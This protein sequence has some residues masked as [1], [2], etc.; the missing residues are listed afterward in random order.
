MKRRDFF[1]CGAVGIMGVTLGDSS[2]AETEKIT[3]W[4]ELTAFYPKPKGGHMPM[5]ELGK[6]GI[7]VS[8]L[9]FGS[10]IRAEMRKYDY[11]REYMMHEAHDLGV[12]VFDVYDQEEG[13]ST[14]GSYQYEPLARQIKPFKNEALVSISFRPYEGRTDEQ[15]LERDLKIFDRDAIDLV[16]ILRQPE[17]PIWG[18]LIKWKEQGKIRAFGAPVHDM[19]HID[20]LVGKVPLDYILFPYNF[21]HNICWLEEKEDDFE[22]VPE[23]LR[24]NGIG[25]VVMKPFA[26]DYLA[27]PF[28]EVARRLRKTEDIDFCQAAIRYVLN[29]KVDPDTMFVGMYNLYHLYDNVA[30]YYDPGMSK[31]ERQLLD[32]M[33]KTIVRSNT[34]AWLPDH[35][36]WLDNWAPR[37]RY[38]R[39]V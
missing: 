34:K 26:G 28:I 36:Q 14:G 39:Q 24:K 30:A 23:R 38:H 27:T 5:K 11:Q 10:H 22:S 33:Q 35:Y 13:V 16:R 32:D 21:Y 2:I 7:K 3:L 29:S 1:K 4:K 12:N 8:R 37:E 6:T 15:E 9:T 18:K 19:S 31:E 20:M 25:V 17:S